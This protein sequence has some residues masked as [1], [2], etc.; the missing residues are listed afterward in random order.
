MQKAERNASFLRPGN[1]QRINTGKHELQ[2]T[3]PEEKQFSEPAHT[4]SIVSGDGSVRDV[5]LLS[6]G[7]LDVSDVPFFQRLLPCDRIPMV[8]QAPRWK[9]CP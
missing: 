8:N 1:T 6:V 2:P 9:G 4:F 3:H 5:A 7:A